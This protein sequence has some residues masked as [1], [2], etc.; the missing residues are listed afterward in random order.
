VL[1]PKTNYGGHKR[2][3]DHA[4][5]VE[6]TSHRGA[7]LLIRDTSTDG[8]FLRVTPTG[9]V[10]F[11]VAYTFNGRERRMSIGAH[12]ELSVLAARKLAVRC[13]AQA[14]TGQ[15][16]L[17]QRRSAR[18]ET[19][20][21]K[22]APT[23]GDLRDH[24]F[25]AH[26]TAYR[27]NGE[28][29]RARS[30][31]KDEERY[32]RDILNTGGSNTKLAEL[33]GERIEAIHRAISKRAP[34][35]A[36]R[37]CAS[38]ARALGIAMKAGWIDC[39][40]AVGIKRNPEEARARYLTEDEIVRLREAVDQNPDRASALIVW[41]ALLTGAR[42]GEILQARWPDIDLKAGVWMKPRLTTKQRRTHRLPLSADA[43]AVLRELRALN[44]SID[45]VIPGNS[46]TTLTRLKR[47]WNA[48]RR[49]AQLEDV[50]FHDLRHAHA[51]ILISRG[52]SLALVGAALGHTQAQTTMRYA[53][54]MDG[55]LRDAANLVASVAAPRRAN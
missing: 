11:G 36:N 2:K 9:R 54:L 15:D 45:L 51:S 38:L 32:W 24:Y 37:A 27:A 14:I 52:C 53:H 8:F 34:V 49:R 1:E 7:E 5:V 55:A 48:I 20:A 50:R 19:L 43:V 40:P 26:I 46:E 33:T 31:I 10:A 25:E 22:R 28:P 16:P 12:P 30:S 23:L 6:L 18:K 47:A 42:R 3:I 41:F 29:V 39:N 44:P 17:E 13:R 4:L 21:A 35:A